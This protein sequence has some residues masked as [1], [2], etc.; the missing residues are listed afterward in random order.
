MND[1][2]TQNDRDEQ[3]AQKLNQVAEQTNV[4]SQFAA[5][6]EERLRNAHQPKAGWFAASFRQVSPVL[7]WVALM[8]LLGLVLSLSIKTL[9]PAPQPAAEDTPAT[10]LPGETATPEDLS[11]TPVPPET[12]FEYD[13]SQLILNVPFPDMPVQA[14]VYTGFRSQPVTAEYARALA[15]QFGIEGPIYNNADLGWT[16]PESPLMV[17][18]GKQ[19]LLIYAENRFTY[20]ADLV[21]YSRANTS[22]HHE[23]AEAIIREFLQAHGFDFDFQVEVEEGSFGVYILYQLAPDGLPMLSDTH[24]STRVTL[25]K[26]GN[27][28]NMS[29]SI[30]EYD[31]TSLGNFGILPAEEA[32]TLMIGE[33]FPIGSTQSGGSAPDTTLEPPQYWYHD[34]PDQQTVTIYGT[35][36]SYPAVD[37]SLPNII[38]LEDVPVTGN[39]NGMEALPS[40]AFIQA[41][42]QFVM[43]NGVR[44]LNVETWSQDV[45]QICV[46]GSAHRAGD[47]IIVTEVTESVTEYALVEPPADLPLDTPFPDKQLVSCGVAVDGQLHWTDITLYNDPSQMGGGGG[48]GGGIFYE[49]NLSGTPVPFPTATP[50]QPAADS[51]AE[52]SAIPKYIVQPNDTLESIAQ[53]FRVSAE[54]IR[55]ANDMP[56]NNTVVT[57]ST[58]IIPITRL[59]GERGA[60]TVRIYEKPDGRQR[61]SYTFVME[62][63][64]SYFELQGD[65][66]EPLQQIVNRPIKIWGELG[67]DETG[68]AFLTMEKFEPIYPDLQFQILTGTQERT[69]IDGEEAILFTT[70]DATYIQR[71]SYGAYPDFNYYENGGEVMLEALQVP[72]ETYA[73][74]PALRV[75]MMAPAVN[76]VTG[77]PME[78]PRR[79]DTIEVMPDPF[80]NAD[81]YSPPD[82]LI[83]KIEL[84][85]FTFDPTFYDDTLDPAQVKLYLQPVWYFRGHN[86]NGDTVNMY[87]QALRQEYLLPASNP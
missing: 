60:V 57:G 15:A 82:I 17:T 5:E 14:N 28:L 42:G 72:D 25:D 37:S 64:E 76:P 38:F 41:T 66:L 33:T 39:T 35:A 27:V 34:Y 56:D 12:T 46:S 63:G 70:G 6:L 80:G 79:A 20:T 3:F 24:A 78:L 4:N 16:P 18:D 43:D 71:S 77:E 62:S 26:D 53:S 7:R 29:L 52:L 65:N 2:F 47:Q 86:E 19:Q 83:E 30:I 61:T 69:E 81:A 85:Y 48:G 59:E 68:M 32:L 8:V 13:G 23:N 1:K 22:F 45:Q 87:I 49:L 21:K 31:P 9:I 40:Y 36:V 55:Q 54:E 58:L 73:G 51:S 67:S 11:T 10:P 74:Y 84:I 50:T 44:K 75:F